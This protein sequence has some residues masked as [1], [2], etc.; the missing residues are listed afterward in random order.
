L[1][2][3]GNEQVGDDWT[4]RKFLK[5]ITPFK[6]SLSTTIRSRPDF[7]SLN[8]NAVLNEFVSIGIVLK[9]ADHA[10]ARQRCLA[11]TPHNLALKS[12]SVIHE[13]YEEDEEE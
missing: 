12:K 8:S 7:A 6:N 1:R 5:A 9:I 2:D 13:E 10:L 11:Q 4:K 3:F